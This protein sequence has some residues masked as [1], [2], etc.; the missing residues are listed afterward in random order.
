MKLNPLASVSGVILAAGLTLATAAP[1]FSSRS[2]FQTKPTSGQTI[3]KFELAERLAQVQPIEENILEFVPEAVIESVLDDVVERSGLGVTELNLLKV[4]RQIWTDSCLGLGDNCK[5]V[6]IPGWQMIFAGKEE[7]WAYRTDETGS[8][9]KLDQPLSQ[10]M[11]SRIAAFSAVSREVGTRTIERHQLITRLRE[12]RITQV[13]QTVA[14]NFT[15]ISADYWARDFIVELA[16]LEVVEGFPDGQFRP[17][18]PVTRAQFAVML[19]KA[20]DRERIN[21]PA[22]FQDVSSQYWA[23]DA[24]QE[25][26]RMGFFELND[27]NEFNPDQGITRLQALVSLTQGLN[28]VYP[29]SVEPVILYYSDYN[30]IPTRARHLIAAA[31]QRGIVVNYPNVRTLNLEQVVTRAEAAA[32][33]YQSLAST[34]RVATISSPYIV[35]VE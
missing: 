30:R 32:F 13:S 19:D 1:S 5:Q 29:G 11:T 28:Y 17:N 35:E 33:I 22:S 10:K 34:A 9:V 21:N 20:F 15:D 18:L 27:P 2:I 16:R 26:Y 3:S 23:H 12:N 14:N 31:T 25:A 4:A 8:L 24:I 6:R 7:M